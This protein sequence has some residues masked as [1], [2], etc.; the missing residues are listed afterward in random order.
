MSATALP[1]AHGAPKAKMSSVTVVYEGY[2]RGRVNHW[3]PT[4]RRRSLAPATQLE[5]S[6]MA[7]DLVRDSTQYGRH[8]HACR[9]QH[10]LQYITPSGVLGWGLCD[11]RFLRSRRYVIHLKRHSS[12]LQPRT[13]QRQLCYEPHPCVS[14]PSAEA[15][16]AKCMPRMF[17]ELA[18]CLNKQRK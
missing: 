7:S 17:E 11:E 3:Q 12:W 16:A 9:K 18:R 5:N 4:V 15:Q 6:T 1:S 8:S 13:T 2:N 14:Y 10:P